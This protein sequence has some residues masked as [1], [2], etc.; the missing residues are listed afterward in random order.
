MILND[1]IKLH[2]FYA[3][4]VL[5]LWLVRVAKFVNVGMQRSLWSKSL[6]Y[7]LYEVAVIC[8]ERKLIGIAE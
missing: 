1:F 6:N 4:W 7:I 5:F 3:F 8:C 2:I